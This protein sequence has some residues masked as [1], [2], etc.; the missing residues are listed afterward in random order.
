MK[1]EL[2]HLHCLLMDKFVSLVTKF[3]TTLNMAP[4]RLKQ[5]AIHS[6]YQSLTDQPIKRKFHQIPVLL[7]QESDS[8]GT[9][10]RVSCCCILWCSNDIE[11]VA[12][13]VEGPVGNDPFILRPGD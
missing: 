6:I 7:K 9:K 1:D 8:L 11:G 13:G 10:P 5:Q 12:S 2:N 3:E 4:S